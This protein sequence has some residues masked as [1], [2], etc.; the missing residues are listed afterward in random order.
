MEK[1][2]K[3]NIIYEDNHLLVI[4]KPVGSS[5]QADSSNAIDLITL[6]KEYR[7]K[8]ETKKVMPI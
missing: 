3:I 8:N 6:L 7:I 1:S 2:P 5:V 4:E